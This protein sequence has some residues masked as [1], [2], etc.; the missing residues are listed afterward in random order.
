MRFTD[1][2]D[3]GAWAQQHNVTRVTFH[4]D[5]T[6]R[7]AEF[8]VVPDIPDE[9]AS[10]GQPR[11]QSEQKRVVSSAL[12]VLRRRGQRVDEDVV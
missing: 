2:A 12:D 7:T 1:P 5:G 9:L 6:V 11:E 8:F 10:Q 4:A 3:L